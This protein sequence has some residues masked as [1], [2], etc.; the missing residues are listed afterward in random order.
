MK[1]KHTVFGQMIVASLLASSI[2]FSYSVALGY[3]DNT[4]VSL[5]KAAVYAAN[6]DDKGKV[7][8]VTLLSY[9]GEDYIVAAND[10]SNQLIPLVEHTVNV[11]GVVTLN[12]KGQKVITISKFEEAFN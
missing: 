12:A 7:T 11:N 9:E 6:Y 4:E 3:D 10:I 8:S 1:I 2:F 5:K